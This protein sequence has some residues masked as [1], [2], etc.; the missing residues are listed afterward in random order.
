MS[1]SL[2][3]VHKNLKATENIF[4]IF[5]CVYT[6]TYYIYKSC[7]YIH[8]LLPPCEKSLNKEVLFK[9][10]QFC[11]LYS[12]LAQ[13]TLIQTLQYRYFLNVYSM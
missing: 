9:Q 5:M 12:Y 2:F 3:Q 1:S 13:L 6:Y 10:T 11:H 7:I 4:I 8:I